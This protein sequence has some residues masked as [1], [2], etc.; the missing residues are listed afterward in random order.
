M[1]QNRPLADRIYELCV[2]MPHHSSADLCGIL[3]EP[4]G[5]TKSGYPY[6][7]SHAFQ[8]FLARVPH[9]F[10][11]GQTLLGFLQHASTALERSSMFGA[12]EKANISRTIRVLTVVTNTAAITAPTDL[13]LLRHVL[14]AFETLN[15]LH[16]EGDQAYVHIP[17]NTELFDPFI[18]STLDFMISRRLIEAM[19]SKQFLPPSHA[20][21]LLL[22]KPW[23]LSEEFR[24]DKV[25][26][27]Q[28]LLSGTSTSTE[29]DETNNFLRIQPEIR[30]HLHW[31]P[32]GSEI[33]IGL[34]LVPTILAIHQ[35]SKGHEFKSGQSLTR[36]FPSLSMQALNLL[37]HAGVSTVEGEV[38]V[39]GERV[40]AKGPGPF[41][42]IYAYH[43]YTH[44]LPEILSRGVSGVWVERSANVA[45]SQEANRSTF[46]LA[47]DKL[48]EFCR[49]FKFEYSVF[50]EHAVGQGEAT[51]QRHLRN[52]DS[53]QYV[54][55]DLETAAIAAAKRKQ[56]AGDLPASMR[57]V[58]QAD[59]GKPEVLLA[60]LKKMSV[61]AQD[62]VMIVGNGFHEV[63]SQSDESMTKVF[64][65]YSEAGVVIIF[66]EE[67]ALA[68]EDLLTTAW[69]TYHAGFRYVHEL[70]GQGL[71]PA[72][73]SEHT[74]RL[75]WK[76]CAEKGGYL[77]LEK[78]CAKT[79][80]IYP[81]PR[82]DG[83]NPSISVTYFCIPIELANRLNVVA[84]ESTTE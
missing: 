14:A 12:A 1:R 73:D 17:K 68:N 58:D 67:S 81:H 69:N 47:N 62:A 53:L 16:R 57:F 55:A 70:S 54:G 78:Y 61:G 24:A 25:P 38:T 66:T 32:S 20:A 21:R 79:R 9:L 82:P 46:H 49:D 2:D 84:R 13:W 23:T 30:S 6:I 60:A 22:L 77:V 44:H 5:T 76:R 83:K 63:R 18:K 71:R 34:R 29:L 65:G 72:L 33:D 50:I 28:R 74:T 3:A 64:E 52:G 8:T 42:I 75:S 19:D 43:S 45:A 11:N 31:T 48:D 7:S 27:I 26:Q 51:R 39:L 40:F 37:F 15:L 56:A 36:H 80:S 59:I 35:T 10:Q 4:C 41:G